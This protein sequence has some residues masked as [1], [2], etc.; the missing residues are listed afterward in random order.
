MCYHARLEAHFHFPADVKPSLRVG[1]EEEVSSL[2]PLGK[3]FQEE[4]NE[5]SGC[6]HGRRN[7]EHSQAWREEDTQVV[8]PP[9]CLSAWGPAYPTCPHT[10]VY[11][12][13]LT[14]S[15]AESLLRLE[16]PTARHAKVV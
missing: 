7:C 5:G 11:R 13:S 4:G 6:G 15:V 14:Y 16:L 3:S 2:P 9:C 12:F 10:P 8:T 1:M